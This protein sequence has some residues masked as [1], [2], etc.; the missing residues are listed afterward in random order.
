MNNATFAIINYNIFINDC[1][2]M[3]P[4][5][6]L[7]SIT[8]CS[9]WKTS[10]SRHK[11]PSPKLE[12]FITFSSENAFEFDDLLNWIEFMK[13]MKFMNSVLHLDSIRLVSDW[14]SWVIEGR[15]MARMLKSVFGEGAW[16]EHGR[17]G[18]IHQRG[19]LIGWPQ[20][21]LRIPPPSPQKKSFV[22]WIN[23]VRLLIIQWTWF[24]FNQF[25]SINIDFI[26]THL[27]TN[28]ALGER[29]SILLFCRLV[30]YFVVLFF[31]WFDFF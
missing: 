11:K 3:E 28:L 16:L 26:S 25:V 13:F 20:M 15:V 18:A 1:L 12:S 7:A 4:T 27:I 19:F 30:C 23:I 8:W 22:L 24:N 2:N 14:I 10:S 17:G 9:W 5:D 6:G 21:P 29:N 31:I